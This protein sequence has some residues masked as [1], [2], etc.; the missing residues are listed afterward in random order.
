MS[1][2]NICPLLL[3]VMCLPTALCEGIL[4]VGPPKVDGN[5]VTVPVFLEGQ[6]DSGVAALDFTFRYDPA[7][8]APGGVR[9]GDVTLAAEKDI[10][11]NMVSPGKYVVMMFGLNQTTVQNGKVVD[12]TMRKL[13]ADSA[14]ETSVSVDGTTLASLEGKTI[15]SRGSSATVKLEVT[16]PDDSDPGDT[17]PPPADETQP[18]PADTSGVPTDSSP[19]SPGGEDTAPDG[20]AQPTLAGGTAAMTAPGALSPDMAV[21]TAGA[22]QGAL[23]SEAQRLSEEAQDAAERLAQL[24]KAVEEL[25]RKRSALPNRVSPGSAGFKTTAGESETDDAASDTATPGQRNV[26][27][28]L[29]EPGTSAGVSGEKGGSSGVNGSIPGPNAGVLPVAT[30]QTAPS[31]GA[32]TAF[33]IKRVLVLAGIGIAIAAGLMLR[34]RLVR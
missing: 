25:E 34:W 19:S 13:T 20:G 1:A 12:I 24:R 33:G 22:G 10:Q 16:P 4:A 5:N 3:S 21:S 18:P 29:P 8:L 9:A 26:M 30:G 2:R 17:T 27:A 28:A 31:R 7:V 14:K 11:Y 6:L 15:A 32:G 23:G